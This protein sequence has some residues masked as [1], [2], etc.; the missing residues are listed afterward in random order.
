MESCY[1]FSHLVICDDIS[2]GSVCHVVEDYVYIE[3][4][5]IYT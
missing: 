4:Y 2:V 3:L 5:I 1:K